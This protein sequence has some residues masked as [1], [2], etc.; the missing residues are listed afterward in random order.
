V[1]LK[2][3]LEILK[4]ELE[5]EKE[6]KCKLEQ[7]LKQVLEQNYSNKEL[8]ER[9]LKHTREE[10]DKREKEL[11]QKN[12]E[13]KQLEKAL[14]RIIE[15][16]G[17]FGLVNNRES[18][19]AIIE[20]YNKKI[21]LVSY[22][23]PTRS[24]AGGLR[25]LDIYKIIKERFPKVQL[26]IYT[27]CR[28]EIEVSYKDIEKIF[29]NI[30]YSETEDLTVLNL[31]KQHKNK[32]SDNLLTTLDSMSNYY[33]IVDFQ[34]HRAAHYADEYRTLCTKIIFTPMESY[35]RSKFIEL[36]EK[37]HT[38][39]FSNKD[40]QDVIQKEIN[41]CSKVD[42]V[43]CVSKADAD[44]LYKVSKSEKIKYLETGISNIEF[45]HMPGEHSFTISPEDRKYNV[46]YIA[47]FGSYTNVD[48]LKWYLE[49]VHPLIKSRIPQ[50]KLNVIG[51]GDLSSFKNKYDDS[52]NFIG[53]V[54][55]L[56]PYIEVAKI[57][58]APAVSGSGFRGKINQYA[59]YGVPCVA[60]SIAAEGLFYKN[61][62]DIYIAEKPKDFAKYCISLLL[63]NKLNKTFGQRARHTAFLHYSW[64]SKLDTIKRIYELNMPKVCAFIPS[65][66]HGNYLKQRIGSILNQTYPNV[67]LTIIDD[68]SEDDSDEII[69]SFQAQHKFRYIRNKCN[70]GT[71]FSS[72][73][74]ILEL[75]T[76][77]FIWI[78]ES[79]DYA[80]PQFLEVMVNA[81]LKNKDAV[82]AYC[83]SWII[84]PLGRSID[85]TDTYFHKTW[86]ESRWN[87]NFVNTGTNELENFQYRGQT[88]P[89]MSSALFSTNSF[90]KAYHP[91]LKKLRLTGDWL[92]VGWIMHYGSVVFCKQKLNYYR[93]HKE[94]CRE[95]THHAYVY[96]EH[97]MTKYLLFLKTKRPLKEL[98]THIKKDILSFLNEPGGFLKLSKAM[99]SISI[100]K[101]LQMF[102]FI[103]ISSKLKSNS[104]KKLFQ[105]KYGSKGKNKMKNILGIDHQDCVLI[106][107]GTGLVGRALFRILSKE[108]FTNVVAIGSKDCDLRNENSVKKLFTSLR[109]NYVFHLAAKV[110]G[111]GGNS[112]YKSDSLF[113]NV[114]INTNV[115]EYSRRA[116]VKKIVAMGSGCVYPELALQKELFED[117]I[118]LGPP[119]S[120]EDSYAHAKRL[121]LAQLLAAKEQ[122]GLVSAFV[123]SGNLY[124]PYDSFNI[125][126]GHVTPSLVAKFFEASKT[127]QPVKVWGSGVAIRDFS[128][129]YDAVQALYE[130]LLK[131]EGPVNMGSGFRHPIKDIVSILQNICGESVQVI[132]DSSKPDG[133]L[134]RYYNLDKLNATDF[135]AQVTLEDGIRRTYNWYTE[136]WERARR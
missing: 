2:I 42:E 134:E 69:K 132:W 14:T 110:Y 89:N 45:P 118:W 58:I 94:T 102:L 22:Y 101:T 3:E 104:S 109:P 121:M 129:C 103:G 66:N 55:S 36:R 9:A 73:E 116:K 10:K 29:D 39:I 84:D 54:D 11:K 6:E 100:I 34:F 26:D 7:K 30:Y 19:P 119:H 71:P 25:T 87:N 5:C 44:F 111:I 133:Q 15:E 50:Y 38:N 125:E 79:D 46:L 124:G 57:G 40:L 123:I 131:V 43:I 33:T 97:I 32:T 117:Q 135:K 70:S 27:F 113:E 24:H 95:Q 120:S 78:C 53:E 99:L 59:I 63:N 122:Y 48:A 105:R 17:K 98:G 49:K 81:L 77:E 18:L 62:V 13:Y 82:L 21:L 93:K 96:A 108:G 126:D 1:D 83:S 65:Y 72:W 91:F 64:E 92:F 86:K 112:K 136:N 23:C 130:I 28:P 90:K 8:M 85:T 41:L 75:S 61:K 20:K 106:T 67:E 76:G 74:Q 51:R 114:M 127:G 12:I 16:K 115:I 88:V 56:E 4:K 68:C 47:Y 80:D 37:S 107:G 52:V 35:S 60:S 31:I 128:Y